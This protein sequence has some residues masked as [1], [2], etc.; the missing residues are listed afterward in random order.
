MIFITGDTHGDFT[1]FST[2]AFPE[3]KGMTKDDYVIICGDFGGVWNYAGESPKEQ[4]WLKWLE[5]KPFTTLF[6]C[7]NHENFNRLYEYP[8]KEWHGGKVHEIRPSVLHLMRGEVF[9]IDDKKF[10]TFGGASSHDI[11]D[12]IIDGDDPDW[13]NIAKRMDKQG[14]WMYR[15]K[16]CSWWERELPTEEEM[17]NGLNNLEKINY[18]VDY[19]VTHTPPAS[20]ITLLGQGF[21]KQ[22]ILTKYLEEIRIKLDYKKWFSGHMHI[23]QQ[24]NTKDIILYDQIVR[25]A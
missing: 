25:I 23:D 19:V 20:L 16:N 2:D 13:L 9:D 3:Q 1:K 14:K 6:C 4:W 17:K 12:G 15:I 5:N 10:F 8:V 24:V 21:Y 18:K 7:G 11:K 22:D